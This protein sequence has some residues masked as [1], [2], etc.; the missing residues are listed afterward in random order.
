M[1]LISLAQTLRDHHKDKAN[2]EC[3]SRNLTM[4]LNL[5][6]KAYHTVNGDKDERKKEELNRN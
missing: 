4:F 6:D 3:L 2:M 5:G 1:Q